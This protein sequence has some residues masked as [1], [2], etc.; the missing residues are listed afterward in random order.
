MIIWGGLPMGKRAAA[1]IEKPW[2]ESILV[3]EKDRSR[4]DPAE[5]ATHRETG[6]PSGTNWL[7]PAAKQG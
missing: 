6:H 2:I 7:G 3:T 5:I 4:S 1:F